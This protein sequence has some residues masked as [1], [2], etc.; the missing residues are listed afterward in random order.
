[1]QIACVMPTLQIRN[2]PQEIYDLLILSAEKSRRSINQ[3]AI[4]L[5]EE[6]LN[7]DKITK[8]QRKDRV[9]DRINK[10]EVPSALVADKAISWIR[11][12]REQ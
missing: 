11:E 10:L 6:A 3:Q 2:C 8:M 5:I 7:S 9:F 1:M 12:D 4:Y